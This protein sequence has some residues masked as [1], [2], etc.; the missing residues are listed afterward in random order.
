VFLLAPWPIN[1]RSNLV[2]ASLSSIVFSFSI[3][4]KHPLKT[5]EGATDQFGPWKGMKHV[6]HEEN[7]G[8]RFCGVRR[9]PAISAQLGRVIG[10]LA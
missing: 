7:E 4:P 2:I 3:L 1:P 10:N 6:L 8:R 9:T 5:I